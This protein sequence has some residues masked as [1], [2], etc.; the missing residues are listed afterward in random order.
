M[1]TARILSL[2]I[3]SHFV[4][5]HAEVLLMQSTFI[6]GHK[7]IFNPTTQDYNAYCIV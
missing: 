2:A 1:S 6:Y 3:Y 5:I 7:L 4:W